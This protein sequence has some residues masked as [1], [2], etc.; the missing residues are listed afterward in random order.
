MGT[1]PP[2]RVAVFTPHPIVATGIATILGETQGRFVPAIFDIEGPEPDIALYDVAFLADGDTTA[3]D[4]LV[5]KTA[6]IVM[7]IG[8]TLRPDLTAR[9]LDHGADGFFD[10]VAPVSEVLQ[11]LE[12]TTTGWQAGDTGPNPTV[13]SSKESRT[14]LTSGDIGLSDREHQILALIA[15]GYTNREIAQEIFLGV[16]TVKTHIRG[17]YRKIGVTHRSG[18]VG[19]AIDH[20]LP[21][22]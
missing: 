3:L 10:L 5:E 20:G 9:A 21:S 19:W 22:D 18:A 11:A 8:T 16:N 17:A 4:V 1:T 6:T 14:D 15:Q 2:I 7:L 12:S 13:G